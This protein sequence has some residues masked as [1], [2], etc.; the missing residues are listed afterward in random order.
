M[1]LKLKPRIQAARV[2]GPLVLATKYLDVKK[3][4]ESVDPEY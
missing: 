3:F 4:E 2:D 1:K